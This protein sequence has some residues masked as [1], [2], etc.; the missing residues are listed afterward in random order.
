MSDE[1][2]KYETLKRI[3][4][5]AQSFKDK[6]VGNIPCMELSIACLC[7]TYGF[8]EISNSKK[9]N[10]EY[11]TEDFRNAV[12]Y[13]YGM[14]RSTCE[15]YDIDPKSLEQIVLEYDPISVFGQEEVTLQS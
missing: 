2:E 4:E 1:V 11:S 5:S 15:I 10:E 13:Q 6:I 8:F 14:Y 12:S 9:K 7:I 3:K